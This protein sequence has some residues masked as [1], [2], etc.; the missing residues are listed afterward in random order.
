MFNYAFT[1]ARFNYTRHNGVVAALTMSLIADKG[2]ELETAL[3]R[4]L[5]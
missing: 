3:K 2:K 1:L 4:M 5:P